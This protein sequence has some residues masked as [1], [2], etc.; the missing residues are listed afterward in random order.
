MGS[1]KDMGWGDRGG[2]VCVSI[3]RHQSP[4][5]SGDLSI[6]CGSSDTKN[7]RL[8]SC[9]EAYG[10]EGTPG[11][12]HRGCDF[13]GWK[14]EKWTLAPLD[15]KRVS[16]QDVGGLGTG[17][18]AGEWTS[19]SRALETG[20]PRAFSPQGH[21]NMAQTSCLQEKTPQSFRFLGRRV[22]L[23]PA[24]RRRC[25]WANVGAS[26]K[27]IDG[28]QPRAPSVHP[29]PLWNDFHQVPLEGILFLGSLLLDFSPCILLRSH[30][31]DALRSRGPDSSGSA[32]NK[33]IAQRA[34]L[35]FPRVSLELALSLRPACICWKNAALVLC[36]LW[37]PGSSRWHT[38]LFVLCHNQA[39][40]TEKRQPW[41]QKP[42]QVSISFLVK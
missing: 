41:P 3:S 7:A 17:G 18:E 16:W 26:G 28:G 34:H 42:E 32:R 5:E 11:E 33:A 39:D 36:M 40:F 25:F 10:G 1:A 30:S 38:P 6:P 12:L 29:A 2:L 24:G 22:W 20:S 19:L 21:S 23:Y 31:R 4:G 8:P 14:K 27:G 35:A 9:Q 15:R 13:F 37:L